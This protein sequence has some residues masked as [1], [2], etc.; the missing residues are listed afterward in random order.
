MCKCRSAIDGAPLRSGGGADA[1][2]AR[3][4]G[5]SRARIDTLTAW[6]ETE[7]HSEAEQAA[8]PY[9]EALTR[10]AD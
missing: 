1:R 6:W 8:L 9:G 2:A 3:E 4:A 7:L 5:I 10:A